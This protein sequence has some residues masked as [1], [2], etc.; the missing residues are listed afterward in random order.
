M[1]RHRSLLRVVF[2]TL[3]LTPR[4]V[5]VA[6]ARLR[7]I[8]PQGDL[9]ERHR[10]QGSYDGRQYQRLS[11]VDALSVYGRHR[12]RWSDRS[13]HAKRNR[14]LLM[15]QPPRDGRAGAAP[16]RRLSV[17]LSALLGASLLM[18]AAGPTVGETVEL[19]PC[20]SRTDTI[21]AALAPHCPNLQALPAQD[22]SVSRIGKRA[23]LRFST[24]TQNV[25][26]GALELRGGEIVRGKSKQRVY[27]RVYA[28]AS[29]GGPPIAEKAVGDFAY[30][31]Q[32]RHFH[33]EDYALYELV[34]TDGSF[35]LRRTSEKTS[36]CVQDTLAISWLIPPFGADSRNYVECNGS[37]QGMS[38][39][40]AD[41]YG[42]SLA[43]Q[44]LDITGLPDGQYILQITVN[45]NG[46]LYETDPSDNVSQQTV[47]LAG[48]Q[49]R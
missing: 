16:R 17:A 34:P 6:S 3:R 23:R 35:D 43:G 44:E 27:Q 37:L 4:L 12:L 9:G 22:L 41:R 33:L 30:H 15:A 20:I 46:N 11:E 48:G 26:P 47:T 5:N 31:P 13:R 8:C 32:H 14:R 18:L 29:S 42:W 39:G 2:A 40:W 45:P 21:P 49:L 10:W 25:G 24:V 38:R 7:S 19:P 36:F 1:G 28:A